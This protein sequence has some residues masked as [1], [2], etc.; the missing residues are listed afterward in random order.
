MKTKILIIP[1][2]ISAVVFMAACEDFWKQCIEGNGDIVSKTISVDEFT[3]IQVKGTFEVTIDTGQVS[4]VSIEIDNNLLGLI[5]TH[6][7]GNTLYIETRDN[8]C[9]QPSQTIRFLVTTPVINEIAQYGS[10]KIFCDG[11][12]TDDLALYQ[13]GTGEIECYNAISDK[14]TLTVEG[15]GSIINTLETVD[16]SS[17][18]EGSGLIDLTGTTVYSSMEVLGSGFI[19]ALLMNSDTSSVYIS[20]SGSV[21]VDVND[22]LDVTIIS[23]GIVRYT[24]D[25]IVQS[26]I[27]GTGQVIKL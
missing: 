27:S 17:L 9:I 26:Y 19:N 4:S 15:S 10:G 3:N 22:F 20:G 16:L 24:G 8:A 25:P 2:I 7:T 13:E 18:I 21:D 6:V 12:E 11:L 23:S 14:S 1:V 5:V